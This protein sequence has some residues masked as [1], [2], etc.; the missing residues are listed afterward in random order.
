MKARPNTPLLHT[1]LLALALA[2]T[3]GTH[4]ASLQVAPTSVTVKAE[5]SAS[6]LTLSNTGDADLHAQVRV[7]RWTQVDGEDKLEPTRDI[8]ISPPMIKLASGAQ[9]LVRV[10]RLGAPSA[11]EGSYR[12][13]VDELPAA[14]GKAGGKPGLE[15]V[16]RYSVPVFLMPQDAS[17][18]VPELHARVT[19][20]Q[21]GQTLE[22]SN[23]GKQHA[24][25]ADLGHVD[26]KGQ[27]TV[28]AAGL[29]GYVLPGQTKRWI[30]PSTFASSAGGNFQ[31]RI[32]GEPDVQT[33]P[34]D[35]SAR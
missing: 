18:F 33:L 22:I 23:G 21:G 34:L 7:F 1:L 27:T 4:A 16:L 9:Q 14:A 32:N 12:V 2:W 24:Q 8:A 30:L 20:G 6:G 29:A 10:I 19:A 28:I 31:A 15:F 3:N 17:D 5:Q 13:I 25:V 11:V 26:G 35:A